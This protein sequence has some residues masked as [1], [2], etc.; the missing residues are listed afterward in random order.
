MFPGKIDTVLENCPFA[1]HREWEQYSGTTW[2][3]EWHSL[4][5]WYRRSPLWSQGRNKTRD[6]FPNIGKFRFRF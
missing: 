4:F 3:S 5:V 2:A 6:Y 1:E